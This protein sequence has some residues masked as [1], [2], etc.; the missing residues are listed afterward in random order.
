MD[1]RVSHMTWDRIV[2]ISRD[3]E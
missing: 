1:D 3:K 2:R